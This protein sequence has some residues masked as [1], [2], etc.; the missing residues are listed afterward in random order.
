MAVIRTFL[1]TDRVM[2]GTSPSRGQGALRRLPAPRLSKDTDGRANNDRVSPSRTTTQ[3][4]F[5]TGTKLTYRQERALVEDDLA[6]VA[7]ATT[8]TMVTNGQ[9][10]SAQ[11]FQEFC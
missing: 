8:A 5:D 4:G 10:T 7:D 6:T 1:L 2:A 3:T 9:I 11:Y